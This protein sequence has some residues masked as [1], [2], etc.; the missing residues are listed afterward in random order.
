Y[1]SGLSRSIRIDTHRATMNTIIPPSM[2]VSLS[3]A[4]HTC[5]SYCGRRTR[6]SLLLKPLLKGAAKAA[7]HCAHRTSTV[8]PCAFC[9][10]EGH[11]AAPHPPYCSSMWY[12]RRKQESDHDDSGAISR[13]TER[14]RSLHEAAGCLPGLGDREW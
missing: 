8:S 9:E 5:W 1:F 2:L 14:R 11:L 13:R 10:H 4:G 12:G 7:L 6:P 3:R